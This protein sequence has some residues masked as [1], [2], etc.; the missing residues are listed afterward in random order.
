MRPAAPA[1]PRSRTL[2]NPTARML[3]AM[4]RAGQVIAPAAELALTGRVNA[5]D[6][7][8]PS[9]GGLRHFSGGGDSARG[10]RGGRG[11][12]VFIFL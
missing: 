7:R 4:P 8:K 2:K 9:E 3:I 1:P 12:S 6:L 11:V 5:P 10:L